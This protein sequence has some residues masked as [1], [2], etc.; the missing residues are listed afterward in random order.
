MT[1]GPFDHFLLLYFRVDTCSY[2]SSNTAEKQLERL[3]KSFPRNN[4]LGGSDYSHNKEKK[5]KKSIKRKSDNEE[6]ADKDIDMNAESITS[7]PSKRLK[8]E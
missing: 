7:S 5:Y 6:S 4:L 1:I 2:S 8:M 3:T